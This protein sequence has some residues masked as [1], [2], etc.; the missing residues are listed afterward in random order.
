MSY[1]TIKIDI[2]ERGVATLTLNQPD[3]HNALSA[4]M[5]SEIS[6]AAKDLG[7]DEKIRA[8]ILTGEGKSFC[9]GGDLGWMREQF[10]ADRQTR[11]AEAMKL[12]T[13]LRDLN[14][15]PKPLIGKVQGQAY[16]GGI[17]MM[18]ICDVAVGVQE[19]KFALTE[20]RLGLI[21]ATISPYVIA[22]MGEG[23]ARRVFMSGRRFDSHEAVDLDL[24]SK[25]VPMEELDASIEAEI[26]PYLATAPGAVA[27]AKI[28]ARSLGSAIG[29]M[30][31]LR[32][33]NALADAWESPE[34]MEGVGAFFEKRKPNWAE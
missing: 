3:K 14:E 18:A 32:S 25:A 13:M 31:M 20:T 6:Q 30:D 29:E 8:I 15:I 7:K 34:A 4:L 22:R 10:S 9:A 11:I 33:A 24:L 23:K 5:I 21:P 12:A 1:E 17:G 27:K 2:D 28:Y 19:A 26:V 16:G